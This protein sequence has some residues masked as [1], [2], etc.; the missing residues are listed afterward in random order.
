[1]CDGNN[2]LAIPLP[3]EILFADKKVMSTGLQLADLVARP[4]GLHTLRPEQPNK[5]F[6]VLIKE[7]AHQKA[8][9]SNVDWVLAFLLPKCALAV[10]LMGSVVLPEN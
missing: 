3:F 5:A 9:S 10:I 7:P 2:R 4:I 8:I 6:D 1:M